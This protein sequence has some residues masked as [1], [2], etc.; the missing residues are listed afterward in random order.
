MAML[1]RL[2]LVP[3]PKQCLLDCL[4]KVVEGMPLW[5]MLEVMERVETKVESELPTTQITIHFLDWGTDKAG[6]D[7]GNPA[8]SFT[9][10]KASTPTYQVGPPIFMDLSTG[11]D[12]KGSATSGIDRDGSHRPAEP[13]KPPATSATTQG[14]LSLLRS[15][16]ELG[17]QN[18]SPTNGEGV[19]EA[20][21]AVSPP[22][23][24]AAPRTQV[25]DM[26]VGEST[27]MLGFI[28]PQVD[29]RWETPSLLLEDTK[30]EV[31]LGNDTKKFQGEVTALQDTLS[32]HDKWI[33]PC[34]EVTCFML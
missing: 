16:G 30:H 19:R 4:S 2:S 8:L 33:R 26:E 17:S 23:D 11:D 12:I 7:E 25:C 24:G 15:N 13:Q 3:R 9:S 14:V 34:M 22:S 5:V 6:Q 1:L 29:R 27:E 18:Y 31:T 28:L 21:E 32:V 10:D 20:Q